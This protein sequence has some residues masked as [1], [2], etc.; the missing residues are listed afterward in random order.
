MTTKR[1]L[2]AVTLATAPLAEPVV[3]GVQ[4]G[5]VLRLAL[6]TEHAAELADMT[7]REIRGAIERREL[8]S[9]I[10]GRRHRILIGDLLAYLGLTPD[11]EQHRDTG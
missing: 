6:T 8:P 5:G 11:T 10:H 2:A 4:F 9:T 3:Y 7:V 1:S